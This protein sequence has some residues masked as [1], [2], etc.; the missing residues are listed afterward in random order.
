[1]YGIQEDKSWLLLVFYNEA[2]GF[3]LIEMVSIVFQIAYFVKIGFVVGIKQINPIVV[4]SGFHSAY[5][6]FQNVEYRWAISIGICFNRGE[7]YFINLPTIV[8][9][10]MLFRSATGQMTCPR[11]LKASLP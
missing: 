4:E 1:M 5:L 3:F 9:H 7:L 6:L 10:P 2:E 11:L 8:Y